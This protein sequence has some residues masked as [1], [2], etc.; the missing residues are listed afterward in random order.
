MTRTETAPRRQGAPASAMWSPADWDDD[1]LR[2]V[3]ERRPDLAAPPP[4]TLAALAERLVQPASVLAAYERLDRS[5]Q[6]VA[7]VGRNGVYRRRVVVP[8][9]QP[10]AAADL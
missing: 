2:T 4:R 8:S 1:R 3:L 10:E 6:Q 7:D 9:L 5:A